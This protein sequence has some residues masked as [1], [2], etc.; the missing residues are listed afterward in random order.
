MQKNNNCAICTLLFF[1]S[2][3]SL[4]YCFWTIKWVYMSCV[5]PSMSWFHRKTRNYCWYTGVFFPSA[6]DF[7][8]HK[9]AAGDE[10]L[11]GTFNQVAAQTSLSTSRRLEFRGNA[12]LHSSRPHRE[13]LHKVDA[14]EFAH[15]RASECSRA[16]DQSSAV[17]LWQLLILLCRQNGVRR[18][19]P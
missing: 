3:Y 5:F 17:L 19:W 12:W 4:L 13:D 18:S 9:G 6:G 8:R 10:K 11:P 7:E 2:L 16:D 1:V 14:I 15:Q